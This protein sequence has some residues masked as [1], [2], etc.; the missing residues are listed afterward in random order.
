M[1]PPGL[2]EAHRASPA[3]HA[4]GERHLESAARVQ[5]D[6]EDALFASL[7]DEQRAQLRVV[8]LVVRD[9]LA[10]AVNRGS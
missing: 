5:R 3:P 4:A 9:G 8:L 10:S 7:D 2:L 1:S 6:T